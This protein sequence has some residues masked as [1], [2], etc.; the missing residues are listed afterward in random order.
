MVK[1]RNCIYIYVYISTRYFIISA[2]SD[3]YCKNHKLNRGLSPHFR[4]PIC[5][6]NGQS[7]HP[8][9]PSSEVTSAML[10]QQSISIAR[11][12]SESKYAKTCGVFASPKILS[13]QK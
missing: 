2:C 1:M 10:G 12:G 11:K 8:K 6:L 5:H 3:L 9:T 4:T 7:G 13:C